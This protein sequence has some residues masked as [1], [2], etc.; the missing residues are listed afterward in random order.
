[1]GRSGYEQMIAEDIR[2]TELFYQLAADHPELEAV[3]QSLSVATFRYIP[4]DLE[5]STE[6]AQAYLNDLNNK[7]LDQLNGSGEMFISNAV[8]HDQFLLR[9]CIVNFRTSEADMQ[10]LPEMVVR[11]GRAL[12]AEMR[13]EAL[14]G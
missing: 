4:A 5:P 14:R 9:I 12:D 2:L 13:P 3:T 10:A 1:V 11:A 7:L 8:I 6:A